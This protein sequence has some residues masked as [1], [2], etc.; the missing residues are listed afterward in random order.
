LGG[1]RAY[2]ARRELTNVSATA[3]TFEQSCTDLPHGRHLELDAQLRVLCGYAGGNIP[4][5][6]DIIL[7]MARK[8]EQIG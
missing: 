8:F 7:P 3:N 5:R 1:Q 4:P 6:C 2:K